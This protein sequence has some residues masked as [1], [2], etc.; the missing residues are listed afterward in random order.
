MTHFS[1][2]IRFAS[3]VVKPTRFLSQKLTIFSLS[4]FHLGKSLARFFLSKTLAFFTMDNL[5][6][7]HDDCFWDLDSR[8]QRRAF[9]EQEPLLS[10]EPLYFVLYRWF[11]PSFS[12]SLFF[13]FI[14]AFTARR[15]TIRDNV[16]DRKE[17]R[18][19]V[20]LIVL[21]YFGRRGV[22]SARVRSVGR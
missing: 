17:G 7:D 18:C 6:A 2:K 12:F 14:H 5:F 1:E 3:L 4:T 19:F 11:F 20:F 9:R 21:T 22:L 16:G 10:N 15:W 8:P 13:S